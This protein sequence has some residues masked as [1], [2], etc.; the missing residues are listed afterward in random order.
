[1]RIISE[2]YKQQM[3]FEHENDESWGTSGPI[4]ATDVKK[5]VRRSGSMSVVDYGCGKALLGRKIKSDMPD[6][7]WVDFDPA[8]KGRRVLPDKSDMVVCTDVMEHVE[9]EYVDNVLEHIASLFE[10]CV[11]LHIACTPAAKK[12]S[13]GRNAHIT[14]KPISWWVDKIESHFPNTKKEYR[15]NQANQRGGRLPK[16]DIALTV[17][18]YNTDAI[19][20]DR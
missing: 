10:R 12:L 18:I 8:V 19:Q 15:K 11:Y 6:L 7:D 17:E 5:C 4:H 13:D 20:A 14:Q 3:T 9:E 1:M 2:A 16:K